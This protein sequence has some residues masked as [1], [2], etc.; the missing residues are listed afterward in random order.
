MSL[1]GEPT[2]VELVLPPA[3]FCPNGNPVATEVVTEV[4]DAQNRPV[5]HVHDQPV[6]SNTRGY[7]TRIT[8]TPTSAGVHY[9]TARFEPGL[10]LARRQQQV[11]LERGGE[12]PWVRTTLGAPCD[13]VAP[14]GGA[15]L[16]RRGTQL[17][18]SRLGAVESTETIAG[19]A[20]AGEVGWLWTGSQL[21]RVV[22]LDGGLTRTALPLSIGP[23]ALAVTEDRWVLGAGAG[24]LEVRLGEDGGLAERRWSVDPAFAPISGPGLALEGEVVG[25]STATRVC[26]GAPDAAVACL[27]TPLQP[28][29]GEGASLWL[30]GVDTGVVAQARV[31]AAGGVPVVLFVPAQNG[32]LMEARQDHPSFSWDGRLVAVRAD[33]LSFEAWRAPGPVARQTA[34]G[35]S[36]VFQ[37]VAGETFVFRR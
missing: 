1:V 15:V 22:E 9:L 8:F 29:A 23:G 20:T 18:I 28:L 27:D 25:W 10:G 14:L 4:L 2:E 32:S 11:A 3:V 35:A 21:S 16:C 30:R 33:D 12:P 6:S 26:A 31:S 5:A 7:S 34:T 36:V 17:Q 37:L 13:E 19:L 24:F